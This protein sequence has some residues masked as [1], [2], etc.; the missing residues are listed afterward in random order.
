MKRHAVSGDLGFDIDQAIANLKGWLVDH[1][2]AQEG[3]EYSSVNPHPSRFPGEP[4]CRVDR[5]CP[6]CAVRM[7]LSLTESVQ[8]EIPQQKVVAEAARRLVEFRRKF[9]SA[10]EAFMA[11]RPV[12]EVIDEAGMAPLGVR[13][14]AILT[15]PI[16][17]EIERLAAALEDALRAVAEPLEA[18]LEDR[19][20]LN[21]PKFERKA[22]QDLLSVVT[23]I[24][25]TGGFSYAD[26]ARLIP[27]V[28]ADEHDTPQRAQDR[29]RDRLPD[30]RKK[31]ESRRDKGGGTKVPS[32]PLAED[33]R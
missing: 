16:T 2:G 22:S 14:E 4:K 18:Y 33:R 12:F 8:R 20:L 26:I 29:V 3:D 15:L 31:R 17:A 7:A 11:G 21:I 32:A 23:A 28:Q 24:L 10:R 5:A 9:L 13:P 6:I 27:D 1:A 30:R 19:F 25:H